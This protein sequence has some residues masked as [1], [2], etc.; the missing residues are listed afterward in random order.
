MQDRNPDDYWI[1]GQPDTDG[2]AVDDDQFVL[3]VSPPA[4]EAVIVPSVPSDEAASEP[5]PVLPE[6]PEVAMPDAS[7]GSTVLRLEAD[8]EPPWFAARG[9]AAPPTEDRPAAPPAAPGLTAAPPVGTAAPRS[10]RL[11][12][13]IVGAAVVVIG[14]GIGVGLALRDGGADPVT[15]ASPALGTVRATVPSAPVS[16]GPSPT[17]TPVEEIR[18]LPANEFIVPRGQ[19]GDH[20]L[21]VADASGRVRFRL[22]SPAGHDVNTPSLSSDR[23]SVRY[24]DRTDDSIRQIAVDGTGDRKLTDRVGSCRSITHVARTR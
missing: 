4:A 11:V 3:A 24:V 22:G 10:R 15:T 20:R 17:S 12:R 21:Y 9:Q 5:P 19:S 1:F 2:P 18:P 16:T 14:G 8:A 7:D 23:R 13:I 6:P